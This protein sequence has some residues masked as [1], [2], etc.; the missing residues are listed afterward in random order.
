MSIPRCLSFARLSVWLAL[1]GLALVGLTSS[2]R[3]A[4]SA[5]VNDA[6]GFFSAAAIDQANA[7]IHA[8]RRDFGK[9]L[10]VETFAKIPDNLQAR[11]Q[12][13][14]KA[15]FFPEWA[16][17]RA[18]EARIVG[19]YIML[20]RAPARLQVEVGK[21]TRLKAFPQS[22]HDRLVRQML[23]LLSAKQYDQAL[24]QAVD[25]VAAALRQNQAHRAMAPP[26]A[27]APRDARRVV[28]GAGNADS[29]FRWLVIAVCV[30]GGLWLLMAIVRAFSG[31]AG[32][33]MGYPG[34]AGGGGFFSSLLGGLFGAAVG[35]WMYDSFFH[36]SG[37]A[38]G[39]SDAYG[40]DPSAPG[41]PDGEAFG[42]GGSAGGDFGGTDTGGDFGGGDFGGGDFG[43]GDFGGGDFGGGGDF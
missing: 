38:W 41:D 16:D 30:L 24:L 15:R 28:G 14:G 42:D 34:G 17:R 23:P 18:A 8:I 7:K 4:V 36:G 11:Y 22:D 12:E 37:S 9:D 32:A 31:A 19:V 35:N 27:H 40:A 39:A 25:F 26:A 6:G 3:A 21:T 43:G 5:R 13:L 33:G 10:L 2:A 20:C 1:A 29:P